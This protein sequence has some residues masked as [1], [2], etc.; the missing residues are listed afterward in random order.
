MALTVTHS[1]TLVDPDSGVEDKVYGAD[2]VAADSH[3]LAGIASAAQGGTGIAFF[4]AAGPTVAR[5]YTFPDAAAT[6]LYAG[7]DLGTPSAGVA[8]NLTGTAAGLTAGNVTTNANLTGIVTSVGNATA[9]ADKAISYTKLADGT[10]GNLITWDANGVA[11]LVPTGTATHVLTSNGVGAAPTFQAAVGG[12]ATLDGITA[13]TADEAGIANADRNIVWNW[14]K[15]TNSE[16]AFTLGETA[17]ATNGT[18]T[19]GVPNQ[20]LVKLATL[21]NSTMSPLS[22]YSREAH[23]FS[24]SPTVAQILATNGNAS[25]PIYGFAADTD[26]G[27]YSAGANQLNFA[28]GGTLRV[29]L[30]NF[31]MTLAYSGAANSPVLALNTGTDLGLFTT[32]ASTHFGVSVGGLELLRWVAGAVQHS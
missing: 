16:V 1:K 15:I 26:N 23:V 6:I 12:G 24:V 30:D 8:T 3:A 29:S 7:G 9:I 22:V 11:A 2:Y 17:A 10:D 4:T 18:S 19:S 21:A 13:A 25:N 32:D 31:R 20:V 28:T 27:M 5:I 14:Q